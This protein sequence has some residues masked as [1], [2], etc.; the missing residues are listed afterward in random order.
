[1][2]TQNG[3]NVAC[4]RRAHQHAANAGDVGDERIPLSIAVTIT[5]YAQH[6]ISGVY[7]VVEGRWEWLSAATGMPAHV[8]TLPNQRQCAHHVG[9]SIAGHV[10]GRLVVGQAVTVGI[11]L[12]A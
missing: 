5:L 8:R 10:C 1:M 11:V 7:A 9:Q 4:S 3:A 12:S 2:A 6:T